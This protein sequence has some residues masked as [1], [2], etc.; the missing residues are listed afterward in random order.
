[1]GILGLHLQS[2]D[3]TKE[4][5]RFDIRNVASMIRDVRDKV[6]LMYVPL[7]AGAGKPSNDV[8]FPV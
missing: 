3:P 5:S 4:I 8:D 6:D 2:G 1:M 7:S